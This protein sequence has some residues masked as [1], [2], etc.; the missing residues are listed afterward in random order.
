M[1]AQDDQISK[2]RRRL[3]K[4]LSAVPVV[5]TLRPGEALANS[6]AFQCV[7]KVR[8]ENFSPAPISAGG[9]QSFGPFDSPDPT[10]PSNPHNLVAEDVPRW[11]VDLANGLPVAGVTCDAAPPIQGFA[12]L[13]GNG[14]PDVRH[15]NPNRNFEGGSQLANAAFVLD[16]GNERLEFTNSTGDVCW[17]VSPAQQG[18]WAKA[19]RTD[20]GDTF[21]EV[22][23]NQ[24]HPRRRI[25]LNGN[26]GQKQAIT[27]T[28]LCSVDPNNPIFMCG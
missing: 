18:F 25:H 6:S 13:Y 19:I 17:V 3:F 16:L 27:A 24:S 1:A 10:D 14:N 9:T 21:I 23:P 7:A 4:A 26:P 22:Y 5:A 2:N 11:Y 20:A 28:C 15:Q 8:A 12:V